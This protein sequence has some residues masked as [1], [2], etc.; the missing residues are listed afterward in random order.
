MYSF[1]KPRKSTDDLL[2]AH[3]HAA[4]GP[5]AYDHA[6]HM[7]KD[8]LKFS[9]SP[10]V[11]GFAERAAAMSMRVPGPGQYQDQDMLAN[12]GKYVQSKQKSVAVPKMATSEM[13]FK[14]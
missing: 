14:Y 11:K 7:G 8:G 6:T 2:K 4:P 10:K 9:L 3:K 12:K 1:G 5:G 13:R